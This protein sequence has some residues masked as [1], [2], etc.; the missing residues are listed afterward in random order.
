MRTTCSD[1]LK[2]G[3][4]IAPARPERQKI[5]DDAVRELWSRGYSDIRIARELGVCNSAA[6]ERRVLLG[7]HPNSPGGRKHVTPKEAMQTIRDCANNFYN[8]IKKDPE[9]RKHYADKHTAWEH[10]EQGRKKGRESKKRHRDRYHDRELQKERDYKKKTYIYKSLY[11]AGI[12]CPKCGLHG[13]LYKQWY[14]NIKLNKDVASTFYVLHYHQENLVKTIKKCI[15]G[16]EISDNVRAIPQI[17]VKLLTTRNSE[18]HRLR[19]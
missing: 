13:S 14:H 6:W 18:N 8:I 19:E 12:T 2:N 7:L 10:S 17:Q 11:L 5:S 1:S 4:R 9:R 15:L 3:L 16:K